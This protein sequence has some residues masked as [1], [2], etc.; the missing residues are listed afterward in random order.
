MR[1]Y[2]NDDRRW[3]E[4]RRAVVRR[5]RRALDRVAARDEPGTLALVNEMD[6][7]CR[8]AVR[9]RTLATG[10]VMSEELRC[11]YC[12]ESLRTG[13]CLGLVGALN[14]MVLNGLWDE[15]ALL[16]HERLR[17]L[18]VPATA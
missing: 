3:E 6:E 4:A 8:E 16:V 15:A 2:E 17:E 11:R 9:A 1:T 13:G 10:N 14:H 5:W 7:F 18:G 12:R